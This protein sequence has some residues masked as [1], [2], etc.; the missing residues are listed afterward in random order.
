MFK[1]YDIKWLSELFAFTLSNIQ[2]K[3]TQCVES[4]IIFASNK[5]HFDCVLFLSFKIEFQKSFRCEFTAILFTV[6]CKL[7]VREIKSE[8]NSESIFPNNLWH[9]SCNFNVT[10][11]TMKLCKVWYFICICDCCRCFSLFVNIFVEICSSFTKLRKL[12]SKLV[13]IKCYV[14]YLNFKTLI[15]LRERYLIV[16]LP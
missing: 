8:R 2:P 5:L 12:F 15:C 10:D 1:S 3:R 6:L 11:F 14:N 7:P 9:K 16:L 4:S 13:L